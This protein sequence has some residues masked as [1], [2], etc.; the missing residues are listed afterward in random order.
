MEP[1]LKGAHLVSVRVLFVLLWGVVF[2]LSAAGQPVV[3]K[4]PAADQELK[5]FQSTQVEMGVPFKVLLYA[6]DESA[7]KGAFDAA[8]SRIAELNSLLSDYD[9]HSE[10]SRLSKASPMPRPRPISP[11]LW[12]VLERSQQ[13]ARQTDGAFDVTVGPYIRL[14]R[15]ARR[16]QQMPSP[17]RLAEAR[18]SVG[19]RHLVLDAQHRT[20]QLTAPR[21][22]LDLGGIA[23]GYAVDEAMQV[24]RRHGITRALIDASGDILAGDPP[25]GERGWKVAIDPVAEDDAPSREMLLAGGAVTTAGDA[26][27]HV[28]LDGKRYSHIVDPR[29]GL[30][31]TDQIAVT[32]IAR[33]CLTADSLDTAVSVLGVEAGLKLI[34]ATPGAAAIFVR[35]QGD[36]YETFVTSR[37]E[38]LVNNREAP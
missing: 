37:F 20:A 25:P 36:T 15:R 31:L 29:T 3:A 17:E 1:T 26:F 27:Q 16:Q 9:P 33:D 38:A 35:P 8:F 19:Y 7:A 24:L 5:R 11:D 32:V 18:A 34:E 12:L 13:L 14:W 2:A 21:M 30:G 10:L 22:Q 28:V 4:P 23:I 6:P